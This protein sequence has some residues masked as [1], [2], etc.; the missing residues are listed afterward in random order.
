MKITVSKKDLMN[1]FTII[2]NVEEDIKNVELC[3]ASIGSSHV[4]IHSE[5]KHVKIPVVTANATVLSANQS[6]ELWCGLYLFLLD[7]DEQPV[8]LTIEENTLAATFEF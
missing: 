2:F 3:S 5:T 7:I 6:K 4:I 1:M 8:I